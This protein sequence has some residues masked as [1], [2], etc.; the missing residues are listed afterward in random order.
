MLLKFRQSTKPGTK[1]SAC[2]GLCRVDRRRRHRECFVAFTLGVKQ[3][4]VDVDKMDST[5]P[6]YNEAR[7]GES[8]RK[9]S[10]TSRRSATTQPPSLSCPSPDGTEITCWN[11]PPRSQEGKADGKCPTDKPLHL[12][13]GTGTGVNKP[14]IAIVFV[15]ANLTADVKSVEMHEEAL[16]EAVPR[17]NVKNVSIKKLRRGTANSPP[18]SSCTPLTI[19]ASS[20]KSRR[21]RGTSEAKSP[22]DDVDALATL[23]ALTSSLVETASGLEKGK[24]VRSRSL[25]RFH[26][27][28]VPH[29]GD[30]VLGLPAF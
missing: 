3:L 14:G 13:P 23:A 2:Y 5:E 21:R 10:P 16:P 4:I 7:F 1:H 11:R 15:P 22:T 24:K 6:P 12:P 20:A 29:P 17:D 18:R 30:F 9:S 27:G 28:N 25:D 26:V 19:L 8:R